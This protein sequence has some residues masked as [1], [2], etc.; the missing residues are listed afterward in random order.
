MSPS[1]PRWTSARRTAPTGLPPA[2]MSACPVS[3]ARSAGLWS[4]PPTKC[5]PTPTPRA[6]TST[7]RSTSSESNPSRSHPTFQWC[8][9]SSPLFCQLAPGEALMTTT[10][11]PEP[12]SHP[13][14]RLL[15]AGVMTLAAA[16]FA[17]TGSA[18]AQ[19]NDGDALAAPAAVKPGAAAAFGPLKQIDADVLSIGYAEAGP[20]DG[21]AVILLHGWPYDIHSY[22]DVAPLLAS[23]GYRVIVPYL[24]GYGTTR[25]LSND[26]VRNGQPSALALDVVSL[27]DALKIQKAIL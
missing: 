23:R 9:V 27:M 24:R 2:S 21:P 20:A 12:I 22:V 15:G 7:S 17:V 25:F 11:S 8:W 1:T 5:V 18:R 19:S 16:E 26:A 14:R 4:R 10:E 6:A 13:R 3:G